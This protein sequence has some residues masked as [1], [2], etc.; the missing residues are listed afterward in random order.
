[1][2][3]ESNPGF[4]DPGRA[5]RIIFYGG[6]AANVAGLSSERAALVD[7]ALARALEEETAGLTALDYIG[8]NATRQA[9]WETTRKF[10]ED[11]DLLLTPTIAVPPFRAGEEGPR[12]VN[13]RSVE[14]FGWTPFTYPFNLTG[15]PALTIPAGF[16]A[17]GLPVGLQIVG[18]RFDEATVLRA[19]AAFEAVQPWAA[20]RPPD[21]EA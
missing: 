7:P 11:Y 5:E 18:R 10:F 14:R 12:E 16:T 9:L 1:V 8:A 2:L 15:N 6:V 3:G 4:T 21:N 19:G 20:Q 17:A 13:G